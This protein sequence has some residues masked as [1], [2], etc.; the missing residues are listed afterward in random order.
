MASFIH[1]FRTYEQATPEVRAA[2]DIV[3]AYH[4]A[5]I[6][7]KAAEDTPRHVPRLQREVERAWVAVE[8]AYER[9][10]TLR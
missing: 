8:D 6:A 1:E 2:L 10:V 7:E 3:T 4:E 5:Q 9:W